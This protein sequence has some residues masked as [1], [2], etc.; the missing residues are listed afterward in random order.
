MGGGGA[1]NGCPLLGGRARRGRAGDT[2]RRGGAEGRRRR[3]RGAR[4]AGGG[5]PR[6]AVR[7]GGGG[8]ARAGTLP[9]PPEQ[10]KPPFVLLRVPGF[11]PPP[12][13]HIHTPAPSGAPGGVPATWGSGARSPPPRSPYLCICA[14]VS[15]F[16][17][18]AAAAAPH[19]CPLGGEGPL[20][21]TAGATFLHSP[22][23]GP[24]RGT[25]AR[26]APPPPRARPETSLARR[27]RRHGTSPGTGRGKEGKAGSGVGGK[28]PATF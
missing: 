8:G 15:V 14:R 19:T 9:A 28:E 13:T 10:H 2:P 24:A 16:N 25:S 27:D 17:P 1:A 18:P 4:R 12:H 20:H 7:G 26:P 5:R 6:Q 11:P 22:N 3:R 23:S 21:V